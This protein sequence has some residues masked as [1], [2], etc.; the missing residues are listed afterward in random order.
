MKSTH[1]R[2]VTGFILSGIL[3]WLTFHKSGLELQNLRLNNRGLLFFVAAITSLILA[4]WIQSIRAKL[5]WID[6]KRKINDI[7][8]FDSLVIGNFYNC[9]LPGNLGEGMRAWHFCK[10]NSVTFFSSFAAVFTEKWIDAQ[11]FFIVTAILFILKPFRDYYISYII[12]YTAII[13]FCLSMVYIAMRKNRHV[14][15]LFCSAALFFK[16]PGRILFQLYW[17]ITQFIINLEKGGLVIQY[18]ILC[19]MVFILNVFQF[20]FLLKCAGIAA[21]ICSIYTAYLTSICMII[22]VFIPAAP[23]NIGVIHYGVYSLLLLAAMQYGI[24]PDAAALHL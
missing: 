16:K 20:L 5:F 14:E 7:K 1:L 23:S 24:K 17:Y 21:P 6:H 2:T 18:F 13:S 9:V 4:V 19:M 12:L 10:K 22:I 8:T 3:L 11:L 15:K